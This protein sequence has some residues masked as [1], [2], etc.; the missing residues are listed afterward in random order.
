MGRG[1]G[2]LYMPL[3]DVRTLQYASSVHVTQT[4][5]GE[6]S[7]SRMLVSMYPSEHPQSVARVEPALDVRLGGHWLLTPVQHHAPALQT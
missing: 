2:L 7:L 5:A 4:E 3:D 1:G 6:P